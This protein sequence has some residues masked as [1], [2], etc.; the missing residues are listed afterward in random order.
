MRFYNIFLFPIIF[1][2]ISTNF[3]ILRIVDGSLIFKLLF[4]STIW[5]I[6]TNSIQLNSLNFHL[7]PSDSYGPH[8]FTILMRDSLK[9]FFSGEQLRNRFEY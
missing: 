3:F 9:Q 2:T 1:M 5:L 8:D 4:A 7:K 6:G